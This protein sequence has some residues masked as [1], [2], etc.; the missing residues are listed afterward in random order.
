MTRKRRPGP[1]QLSFD[2]VPGFNMGAPNMTSPQSISGPA[3]TPPH[4]RGFGVFDPA[5]QPHRPAAPRPDYTLFAPPGDPQHHDLAPNHQARSWGRA[6]TAPNTAR[7]PFGMGFGGT[8]EPYV[9][10]S[11]MGDSI[12]KKWD[13]TK[14]P[15]RVEPHWPPAD[16]PASPARTTSQPWSPPGRHEMDPRTPGRIEPPKTWDQIDPAEVKVGDYYGN[17]RVAGV[18]GPDEGPGFRRPSP[19]AVAAKGVKDLAKGFVSPTSHPLNMAKLRPYS[20]SGDRLDTYEGLPQ[21]QNQ[22]EGGNVPRIEPQPSRGANFYAD[23]PNGPGV[24][25]RDVLFEANRGWTGVEDTWLNPH[26][27]IVSGVRTAKPASGI[28]APTATK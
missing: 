16:V 22:A 11:Q 3:M 12:P 24:E 26:E 27:S 5:P 13:P 23:F 21:N 14:T 15:E 6:Q 10:V 25:R 28:S 1:G 4:A 2:T 7:P 19:G 20:L 17:A 8:P 18:T 9:N